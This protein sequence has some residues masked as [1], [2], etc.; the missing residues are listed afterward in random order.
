MV[1]YNN[2]KLYKIVNNKDDIILLG[3]TTTNYLS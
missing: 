3:V 1:N 2:S